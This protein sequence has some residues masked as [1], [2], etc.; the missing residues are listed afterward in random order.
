[1]REIVLSILLLFSVSVFATGGGSSNSPDWDVHTA[2]VAGKVTSAGMPREKE[3]SESA[4]GEDTLNYKI[5]TAQPA[6]MSAPTAY[7]LPYEV[8]WCE[9]LGV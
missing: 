1:M 2:Q 7:T 5:N 9:K 8:G 3:R 4:A 6:T